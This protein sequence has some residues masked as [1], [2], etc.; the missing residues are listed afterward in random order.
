MMQG[1]EV[2]DGVLRRHDEKQCAALV[3]QKQVFGMPAG[4]LSAQCA[5]LLDREHGRVANRAVR[6]AQTV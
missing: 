5:R 3:L 4:N 1:L 2:D 6:D